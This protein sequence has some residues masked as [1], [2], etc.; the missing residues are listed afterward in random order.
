VIEFFPCGQ[1]SELCG[2]TPNIEPK[3][4]VHPDRVKITKRNNALFIQHSLFFRYLVIAHSWLT[5]FQQTVS[6]RENAGEPGLLA[7]R[8]ADHTYPLH[9][10]Q[11]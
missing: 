2:I 6:F 7:L 5:V 1:M 4:P 3:E 10:N 9:T 11:L 8:Y